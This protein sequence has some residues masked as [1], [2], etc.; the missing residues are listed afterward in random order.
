MGRN[1][2]TIV[3][4]AHDR[5]FFF[6]RQGDANLGT[7]RAELGRIIED[8]LKSLSQTCLV[9]VHKQGLRWQGEVEAMPKSVDERLG[10]FDGEANGIGEIEM[11][12]TQTDF[13]L[14]NPRD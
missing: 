12:P 7:R 5:P 1:A 9:R 2:A 8:V 10:R 6:P 4:E 3:A 13:A 11:R 14:V